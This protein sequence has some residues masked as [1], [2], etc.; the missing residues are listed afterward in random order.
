MLRQNTSVATLAIVTLVMVATML[1][2]ILGVI[3]YVMESRDARARLEVETATMANQLAAA[4]ALPLWNFDRPQTD[5]II[6][7]AMESPDV[8]AVIVQQ[9]DVSVPGGTSVHTRVR[10]SHG[11]ASASAGSFSP[12]GLLVQERS[13]ETSGEPLGSVKIFVTTTLVE[14]RL[15]K[16]L[17]LAVGGPHHPF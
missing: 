11:G 7:I 1:L 8:Y 15:R 2:G 3:N 10:D 5:K 13:I 6:E 9:R 17:L 4:L 14:Q 16:N 12:I